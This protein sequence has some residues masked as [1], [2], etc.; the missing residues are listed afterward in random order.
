M[1]EIIDRITVHVL[2][3]QCLPDHLAHLNT[4]S[5]RNQPSLQ[6]LR[7]MLSEALSHEPANSDLSLFFA[8]ICALRDF[9]ALHL[10]DLNEQY[11]DEPPLVLSVNR[12]HDFA[13]CAS[14]SLDSLRSVIARMLLRNHLS[15]PFKR[16]FIGIDGA[17]RM[18]C[19]LA[20]HSPCVSRRAEAPFGV[21]FFATTASGKQLF[22]FTFEASLAERNGDQSAGYVIIHGDDE[23][24]RMDAVCDIFTERQRLRA[25]RKDQKE[26]VLSAWNSSSSMPLKVLKSAE[27]HFGSWTPEALREAMYR[28]GL[29]EPTQFKPSL[30]LS[31]FQLFNAKNVLDFSAGWGDRLLAAI[32]HGVSTYCGYDPN[33]ELK[34]GHTEIVERYASSSQSIELHYV[35]FDGSDAQPK[36]G[37]FDLVFTSPPF[38]DFEVYASG[39]DQSVDSYTTFESWLGKFLL[40][41]L[42][43]SW[44]ALEMGGRC[45]VHMTDPSSKMRMCEPLCLMACAFLP[46]CVYEGILLSRGAT[47][48]PRPIWVFR[49]IATEGAQG[50]SLVRKE[51]ALTELRRLYPCIAEGNDSCLTLSMIMSFVR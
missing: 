17:D 10:C 18:M 26:S 28:S 30:A 36:Q 20:C 16:I 42:C 39:S 33:K 23:Y 35:P 8:S 21:K 4:L 50:Y 3:D 24:H 6:R 43:K 29:R 38:F 48:K 45:V 15:F 12:P 34:S 41:C 7:G 51:E 44:S 11:P 2:L 47:G 22:P 31:M 9:G 37:S 1:A 27:Q 32:A 40:R 49:K 13:S 14:V 5:E 46:V 25:R 19:N